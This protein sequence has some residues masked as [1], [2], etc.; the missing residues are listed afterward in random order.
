MMRCL[1]FAVILSLGLVS[2]VS[3]EDLSNGWGPDYAWVDSL[4]A[5]QDQ[6][7]QEWKPIMLIIHKSWCG[8]CKSLKS[9]FAKD[10]E[11]NIDK[12]SL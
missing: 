9:L 11:V 5:A 2:E 8:A 6:A 7:I 10:N 12:V 4:E 3:S 1:T